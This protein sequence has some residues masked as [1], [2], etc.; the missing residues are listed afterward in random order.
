M[1]ALRELLAGATMNHRRQ[2]MYRIIDRWPKTGQ[3]LQA[4]LE[5]G[6]LEEIMEVALLNVFLEPLTKSRRGRGIQSVR[7]SGVS[8]SGRFRNPS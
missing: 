2:A 5:G 6:I 7:A 8:A 4:A 3:L 1:G